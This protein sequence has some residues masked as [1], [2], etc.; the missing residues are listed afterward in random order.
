MQSYQKNYLGIDISKPYF[1]AS[2][3]IVVEHQKQEM[4]TSRFSNDPKGLKS[5]NKWLKENRVSKDEN[6]ICV[7]E[8]T[9]VYHRL[10]WQYC[11]NNNINIHIGNATHM[12]WSFGIA[13][14]KNDVIDSKR[15]CQ[16]ANKFA[17]EIKATPELNPVFMKLKDLMTARTKLLEQKN[18]IK[19]YLNELKLS[20]DKSTQK[21]MEQSFKSSIAGIQKSILYIE[22]EINKVMVQDKH[23]EQNY[24]LIITVPGVGKYTALYILCCTNNFATKIS[25]KQLA[26]YAGVVP[27]EHSSGIS[28]R[29]G[30]HVHKMANKELKSL[31]HMCAITSIKYYPEFKTYFERKKSEGKNGMSV[32]NAIKNKI[33]LRIVAV[34][35]N[36]KPYVNNYISA[37]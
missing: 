34:V 4:K 26:S 7:I 10:L 11:S 29:G 19:I 15:I 14:G 37:A 25:G 2:L 1:D 24:N 6:T 31:L 8:N 35:N 21:V 5:F 36:Q 9:G 23:I 3:L 32:L 16:Y 27:F 13:R 20:N 12:K 33:V 17:D 18:S 28:V 30:N 22:E